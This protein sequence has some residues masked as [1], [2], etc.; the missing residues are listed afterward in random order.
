MCS[1]VLDGLGFCKKKLLID[2]FFAKITCKKSIFC[3]FNAIVW[4]IF[5]FFKKPKPS[6][7]S[8]YNFETIIYILFCY[9]KISWGSMRNTVYLCA[10]RR[11]HFACLDL[12]NGPEFCKKIFLSRLHKQRIKFFPIL[13]FV[14]LIVFFKPLFKVKCRF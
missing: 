6:R 11:L 2:I 5:F 4:K 9:R 1:L 12:S 14:V 3:T 7:T 13:V 10:E 8:K